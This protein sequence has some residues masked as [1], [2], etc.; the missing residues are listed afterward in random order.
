VAPLQLHE[1]MW[2]PFATICKQGISWIQE[3][4][5]CCEFAIYCELWI[6]RV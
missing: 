1:G 3:L 2:L 4:A 5:D 6:I